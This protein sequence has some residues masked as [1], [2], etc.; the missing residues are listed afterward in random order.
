M[1]VITVNR[2]PR[3]IAETPMATMPIVFSRFCSGVRV[4]VGSGSAVLAGD[5]V[6]VGNVWG[7]WASV[8]KVEASWGAG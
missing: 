5:I 6:A 4:G 1:R 3:K 2:P 7:D 8:G